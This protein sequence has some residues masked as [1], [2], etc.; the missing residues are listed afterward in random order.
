MTGDLA[1]AARRPAT[2]PPAVGELLGAADGTDRKA[3]GRLGRVLSVAEN[4]ADPVAVLDLFPAVPAETR[5]LGITG[6]PGAGKSTLVAAL[7]TARQRE[8]RRVAV[9]AIDPSSQLSGGALLGDRIR[10]QAL[11]EL[12]GVFVRSIANRG[13]LGGLAPR[14][15]V[16]IRALSYA[17]FDEIIVETVGVGQSE[18]AVRTA[19]DTSVVVLCPGLGDSVQAAKAG[20]LEI[21]DIYVV[22]KADLPDAGDVTRDLRSAVLYGVTRAPGAWLPAVVTAVATRGELTDLLRTLGNHAS[23]LR[24]GPGLAQRRRAAVTGELRGVL[25]ACVQEHLEA[26]LS[27]PDFA[28][29]L[30]RIES[31]AAPR[32]D[33]IQSLIAALSASLRVF[34][35]A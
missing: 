32:G 18:T 33:T 26:V 6:P 31:G 19:V 4:T 23:W 21:A 5:V 13:H 11:S 10:M 12:P 34:H 29:V 35:A 30:E 24:D 27:R 7:V 16:M 9:L 20:V 15:P 28:A 25:D 8:G 14:L 3:I 22:N 1:F 17:G 2:E